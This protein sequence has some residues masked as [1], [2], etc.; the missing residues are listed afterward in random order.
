MQF[1]AEYPGFL[2]STAEKTLGPGTTVGYL[3]GAL[4]SSGPHAP[5]APTAIERAQLMGEALA[6]RV[7][8]AVNNTKEDAFKT[9]VDIN[10]IGG[11]IEFP[12]FQI[13]LE[14]LGPKWRISPL[15]P[16]LLG[17]TREGWMH[18]IQ[19]G[20]VEMVGV[21]GD[22]SSEISLKWKAWA[23]DRGIDLWTSSFC[24]AYAG[25]ISQDK[26]Y[27]DADVLKKY[28][29]GMMSWIGPHQ[30][31]FFTALMN[32]MVDKLGKPASQPATTTQIGSTAT[33]ATAGS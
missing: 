14:A 13:R 18:A 33:N 30:E 11:P 27:S 26:Y 28:E 9:E 29:T 10:A 19:I 24:A 22:F 4:G 20:D 6:K 1:T 32:H 31:A 7:V 12:P 15:L 3:G 17:L 16:P 5:E 2:Q 8:E 25:Y 21:P 23:A